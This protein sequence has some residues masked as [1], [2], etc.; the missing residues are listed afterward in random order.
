L[1]RL[2]ELAMQDAAFKE[3]TAQQGF[4]VAGGE[5]EVLSQRLKADLGEYRALIRKT[6]ITVN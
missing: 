1:N 2:L 5:P 4:A 6:G 3:A